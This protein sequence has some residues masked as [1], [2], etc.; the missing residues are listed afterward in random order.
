MKF[1]ELYTQLA[2]L[3]DADRFER[4]TRRIYEL[5]KRI[6][7]D[8]FDQSTAYVVEELRNAGFTN[9]ERIEHPADGV[10][11][12]N[13]SVMP[14]AWNLEGRAYLQVTTPWNENERII[15]DTDEIPYAALTWSGATPDEGSTGELIEYDPAHPEK[16]AGKWVLYN[17]LPTG[18]INQP[19]VKAGALGIVAT[20]FEQGWHNPD[21]TRWMNGQGT[22]GWYYL[23]GEKRIPIFAITARRALALKNELKAGHKVELKGVLKARISDGKIYTVTGVIPGESSE[24]YG[25]LAHMYEPFLSDDCSGVAAGIEIGRMI[26]ESGLKL[27]KS[28]RVVFSFEHYGFIFYLAR[29]KHN[30][31]AALNM[32]ML[33]TTMYRDLGIPLEWRLSTISLPFFG[34]LLML[35]LLKK[36][37]P[38]LRLDCCPGNLSDDTIGGESSYNVPTN[39]LFVNNDPSPLHHSSAPIFAD[40][41]WDLAAKT[42]KLIAVFIAFLLEGSSDDCRAIKNDLISIALEKASDYSDDTPYQ[43]KVRCD[44]AVGQLASVNDWFPGVFADGEIAALV[45]PIRL[46]EANLSVQTV[47]EKAAASMFVTRI[48]PGTPWSLNKIPYAERDYCNGRINK[49]YY[50]LLDGSRSLLESIRMCDAIF[51]ENT[52]EESLGNVIRF[53][54]YL[55]RYG[56]VKISKK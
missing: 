54:Y 41:D 2:P 12:V 11:C 3:F 49:V 47:N 45:E 32:D 16:A 5:E 44:F 53:M 24:E 1:N 18:R 10:S 35:D 7:H 30:L 23:K 17:G 48:E 42:S 39:W 40:V 37:A 26:K 4:I 33:A 15:A 55:E 25:M 8:D 9:V 31:K 36:M 6:C 46:P 22:W 19:L 20:D 14:E 50:T 38:E 56:Y 34:D 21:S 13:D 52:S 27:K 51:R 29:H 28:L 43:R